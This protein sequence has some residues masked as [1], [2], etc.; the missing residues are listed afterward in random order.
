MPPVVRLCPM[1]KLVWKKR[2]EVSRRDMQM[3][4]GTK[5]VRVQ[6]KQG[7]DAPAV[8]KEKLRVESPRLLIRLILYRSRSGLHDLTYS[9]RALEFQ[10]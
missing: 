1:K 7:P 10:Y 4:T 3:R 6:F 2:G 5:M 8:G 9:V